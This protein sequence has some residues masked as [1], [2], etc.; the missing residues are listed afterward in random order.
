MR[1]TIRRLKSRSTVLLDSNVSIKA[2]PIR[3]LAT[4]QAVWS[5]HS[6]WSKI[7]RDKGAADIARSKMLMAAGEELAR[8]AKG[9]ADP[10][11]NTRLAA[12]IATAK[13]GLYNSLC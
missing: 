9:G 11:L 5:G 2:V 6:K 10:T 13:K 12:A 7:K 1:L 4:S 3:A 8:A